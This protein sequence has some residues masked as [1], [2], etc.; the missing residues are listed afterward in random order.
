MVT[1]VANLRLPT[2]LTPYI[3]ELDPSG[4]STVSSLGRKAKGRDMFQKVQQA[5]ELLSDPIRRS[6]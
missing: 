3:G 4:G 2:S 1:R 5:Y 6:R